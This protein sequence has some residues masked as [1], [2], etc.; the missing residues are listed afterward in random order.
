MHIVLKAKVLLGGA[1]VLG[2]SPECLAQD[3][4]T[5]VP[6]ILGTG[7]IGRDDYLP[8]FSYAGYEYGVAPIPDVTR[9]IA[10]ADHGAVPDDS[11]DDSEASSALAAAHAM[12][13]PVRVQFASGRYNLSD[14]L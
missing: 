4:A 14:I 7:D 11:I 13:G 3:V 5:E 6:A 9:E 10:F 2:I 12:T 8:D 1:A